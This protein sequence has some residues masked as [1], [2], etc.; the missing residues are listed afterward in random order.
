MIELLTPHKIDTELKWGY[1]LWKWKTIQCLNL[2]R[3]QFKREFKMI[4]VKNKEWKQI[5]K[6]W[7]FISRYLVSKKRKT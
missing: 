6:I 1:F 3:N 4:S 2:E 5:K 7:I